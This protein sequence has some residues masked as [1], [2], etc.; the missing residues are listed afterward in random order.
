MLQFARDLDHLFAGL[1]RV[2]LDRR[3]R[4]GEQLGLPGGGRVAAGDDDAFV[5]QR[6]ENRQARERLHARR[7]R[8]RL[9]SA[10]SCTILLSSGRHEPQLVPARSA[11][12]I[13]STSVA[14]FDAR[15]SRMTFNPTPKQAQMTG[16][17]LGDAIGGTARQQHA[18]L[19]L[20]EC[21]GFEQRLHGVPL[22]RGV[23]GADEQCAIESSVA[24]RRRAINAAGK[25]DEF[26][27]LVGVQQCSR[28]LAPEPRALPWMRSACRCRLRARRAP[29][30]LPPAS[31][32]A[33]ASAR[34]RAKRN[35]LARLPPVSPLPRVDR[36]RDRSPAR[37]VR[38][39]LADEAVSPFQW[40]GTNSEPRC[41]PS[42]RCTRKMPAPCASSRAQSPSGC[43]ALASSG[44]TSTNGSG[45][46][47]AEPRA[48]SRARHGVPLVAHAA[49]VQH[50]GVVVRRI[51]AQRRRLGSDEARLAVRVKKPPSAKKRVARQLRPRA[52]AI[53]A[54]RARRTPRC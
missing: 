49:G 11:L 28:M 42:L 33:G 25:V 14:A 32:S 8:F 13:A 21:F 10:W 12:P 5:R 4:G 47:C 24:E 2:H 16:P 40:I 38:Q 20:A 50:E 1:A 43:N 31:R 26:G 37:P 46:C 36:R 45:I 19:R 15:A 44:C 6:V 29:T 18:A 48:E 3:A 41:W 34:S 51:G 30:R 35:R 54:A 27:E 52:P 22:R 9:A 53:R 39:A 23:S 17:G 7:A